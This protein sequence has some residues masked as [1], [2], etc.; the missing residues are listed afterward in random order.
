M[1]YYLQLSLLKILA[2][3]KLNNN[4]QLNNNIQFLW[5]EEGIRSSRNYK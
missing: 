2:I 1:L 4:F 3:V 5:A